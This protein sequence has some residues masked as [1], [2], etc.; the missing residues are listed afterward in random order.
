M[1]DDC[2]NVTR[3]SILP[4][5]QGPLFCSFEVIEQTD[6]TLLPYWLCII[7]LSSQN[8]VHLCSSIFQLS[9]VL[10]D[11]TFSNTYECRIEFKV[12]K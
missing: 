7:K 9:Q 4:R 6:R 10:L 1:N 11:L 12:E 2:S 3:F 8:H 5:F